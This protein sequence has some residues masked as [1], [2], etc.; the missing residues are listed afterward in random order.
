MKFQSKRKRRLRVVIACV[1]D[2]TRICQ[3]QALHCKTLSRI[4]SK[5]QKGLPIHASYFAAIYVISRTLFSSSNVTSTRLLNQKTNVVNLGTIQVR[6]KDI[7][8]K[9]GCIPLSRAFKFLVANFPNIDNLIAH[10][11][12]L[13]NILSSLTL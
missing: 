5:N 2:C 6:T 9:D 3:P 10:P 12:T 7:F 4:T 8:L 11:S 13:F 1:I